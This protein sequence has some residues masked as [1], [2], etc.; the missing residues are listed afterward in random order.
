M[1]IYQIVTE[2]DDFLGSL[3][4]PSGSNNAANTEP[5]ND[6]EKSDKG[7]VDKAADTINQATGFLP[8]IGI[9]YS[10]LAIGAAAVGGTALAA[11]ATVGAIGKMSSSALSKLSAD[12]AAKFRLSNRVNKMW[13]T[14]YGPWSKFF[15]ALGIAAAVTQLYSN[16]YIIEA[17]YVQN[18]IDRAKLEEQRE[19]E[20][21]I[22]EVQ[23]L[24]PALTKVLARVIGVTSAVKW[25]IRILGGA[26]VAASL[27]TSIAVTIA[28]E[29][30]IRWFQH[31]LGTESGRNVLYKYFGGIVRTIGKPADSLWNIIMNSYNKIDVKKYGSE[32]KAKAAQAVDKEKKDS[33]ANIF[34]RSA[35]TK[36]VDG[37]VVTDGEGY[38]LPSN[39]LIA[40]A[41]LQLLRK[42][43]AN[44]GK[45]DPLA[46]IPIKPGNKLPP[47]I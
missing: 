6:A 7:V 40:N 32:E 9:D 47:I 41:R 37:I 24:A 28:S 12:Y 23:V 33:E 44:A 35:K 46:G 45:P 16:L 31:W 10:T 18:K 22:F 39:A 14:K 2:D 34:G 26:S 8:D 20:F 42:Q 29:A 43:A 25:F 5:K 36:D 38:L 27:G 4:G 11:N 17:L 21:G 1:K 13:A 3:W 19:F 15:S 30:F